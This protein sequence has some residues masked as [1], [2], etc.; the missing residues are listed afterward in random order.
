MKHNAAQRRYLRRFLPAM[1]GYVVLLFASNL[2]VDRWRPG[3]TI[4]VVL[5]ILPAMPLVAV[6]AIMGFYLAEERDDFLRARLV[7]AML[8]GLGVLL[9]TATI[10]G[11]LQLADVIGSPPTFLAFPLWCAAF[12]VAQA[13]MALA[14]KLSDRREEAP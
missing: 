13:A 12:G 5:A 8:V 14:D 3:G 11:F 10:W 4:L 6:I 7:T 1:F 2:M 9:A